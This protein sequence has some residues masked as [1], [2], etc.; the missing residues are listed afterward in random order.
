MAAAGVGFA[1][2]IG[3]GLLSLIPVL[4]QFL[5]TGLSGP[6]M[7]LGAGDGDKVDVG[8]L[9]TAVIGSVVLVLGALVGAVV[10]FRRRE[11]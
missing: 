6:A 2:L 8:H 3:F 11:L 4:D 5:P 7:A 1:A 10:S 9:A